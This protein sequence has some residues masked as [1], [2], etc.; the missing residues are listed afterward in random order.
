[1]PRNRASGPAYPIGNE[2]RQAV[3]ERMEELGWG[4]ARL[5]EEAGIALSSLQECIELGADA[6]TRLAP[7]IHRALGW[8][9]PRPIGRADVD[10][11][12]EEIRQGLLSMDAK[13]REAMRDVIRGMKKKP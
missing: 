2:W 6:T 4:L 11:V 3:L 12:F 8:P 5:A 13:T 1:M 7:H 9:K 10:P